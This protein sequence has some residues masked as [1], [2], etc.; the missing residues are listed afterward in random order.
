MMEMSVDEN[1]N[2][3]SQSFKAFVKNEWAWSY[4]FAKTTTLYKSFAASSAG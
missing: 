1:I 4:N 2:L 3:D